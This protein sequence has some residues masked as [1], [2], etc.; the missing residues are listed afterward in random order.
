MQ[1]SKLFLVTGL[2]ALCLLVYAAAAP[3]SL[4]QMQTRKAAIQVV[5]SEGLRPGTAADVL[6]YWTED[7]MAAAIPL[8]PE[9]AGAPENTRAPQE[10]QLAGAGLVPPAA[11]E[12][13]AAGQA[14]AAGPGLQLAAPSD[15]GVAG[16]GYP[17]PFTRYEVFTNYNAWPYSAN[18]K[19][20][21][22]N[23]RDNRNYVCSGTAVNSENKRVVWT[24]G[25]CVHGGQGGNWH[26]HWVFVP[27]RRD[28]NNPY[29]VWTASQLWS[30]SGWTSSSNVRYDQG[31]V[32]IN[33]NADGQRLINVVGGQGIM[34]NFGRDQHFHDFG[35]P[36]AS[37]FHGERMVVCTASHAADDNP[38]GSGPSTT[39]IGCD[40]TGGS[41]GG[42]WV[43]G[44]PSGYLD[45]LNSYKYSSQP[46]A[47]YGPYFGDGTQS[48]YNAVRNR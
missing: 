40:M 17:Y 18:G 13:R 27:A 10:R 7:R 14:G 48:L 19:V 43:V 22:H 20:F 5:S 12:G 34:W 36:A 30:L 2:A 1:R 45:G 42:G 6:A 4:A 47:M 11:P 25:H 46:A 33:P 21:F 31:A 29:G 39:G 9:V 24:A 16:Y 37:P 28:G 23:T 3:V 8:M 32:L 38:S 41:S 26:D 15:I 44:F 35:Y